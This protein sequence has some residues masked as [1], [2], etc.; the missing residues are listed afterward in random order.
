MTATRSVRIVLPVAAILLAVTT[1]ATTR[2]GFD[3]EYDRLLKSYAAYKQYGT[4]LSVGEIEHR[5]SEERINTVRGLVRA[6]LV[7][8]T[9][10]SPLSAFIQEIRGVWGVRPRNPQGKH[11]FRLSVYFKTGVRDALDQ[12]KAFNKAA[13]P[14]VL[15]PVRHGGDDDP[16]FKDFTSGREPK[17]WRQE[18]DDP[19]RLQV[20]L[21]NADE[22]IGEID[23]DFHSWSHEC[24]NVP[25]NSDVASV[26]GMTHS[27]LTMLNSAFAFPPD[28]KASCHN[29][30]SHCSDAYVAPYCK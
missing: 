5:L 16:E 30:V 29:T 6:S 2:A 4:H 27:H 23:V 11:Q 17:T 15:L 9:S 13:F 28:L 26:A 3:S 20:S 18:A 14:H 19:P 24:H 25:A 8:V 7:E 12:S 22:R 21:L 1:P 10:G